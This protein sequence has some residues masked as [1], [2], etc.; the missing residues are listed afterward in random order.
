VGASLG[1]APPLVPPQIV[2]RNALMFCL[3]VAP[4]E[5][6]WCSIQERPV[7]GGWP[8]CA[9]A[10]AARSQ[11]LSAAWEDG[12]SAVLQVR[13]WSVFLGGGNAGPAHLD[14]QTCRFV[15]TV[16]EMPSGIALPCGRESVRIATG[17]RPHGKTAVVP[18]SRSGFAVLS[19]GADKAGSAHLNRQTCRFCRHDRA[20]GRPS[21]RAP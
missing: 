21:R 6:S 19:G 7:A 17:F 16:S 10:G 13:D 2:L 11:G 3:A 20:A 8:C 5:S 9:G 4:G 14:R 1:V 15:S 18:Y 12:G